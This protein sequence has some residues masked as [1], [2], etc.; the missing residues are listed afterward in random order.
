MCR[1]GMGIGR[2]LLLLLIRVMRRR[3]ICFWCARWRVMWLAPLLLTRWRMTTLM[4]LRL[5]RRVIGLIG[6]RLVMVLRR[7]VPRVSLIRRVPLFTICTR[8]CRRSC[9]WG[10]LLSRSML[11]TRLVSRLVPPMRMGLGLR[12]LLRRRVNRTVLLPV[13]RGNRL[14]WWIRGLIVVR[15]RRVVKGVMNRLL[16]LIRIMGRLRGMVP[17]RMVR[18]R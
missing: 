1:R 11:L 17:L 15:L 16:V 13:V 4:M 5:R 7:L 6:R 8:L 10:L 18:L 9:R 12:L 2:V 3:R 14:F